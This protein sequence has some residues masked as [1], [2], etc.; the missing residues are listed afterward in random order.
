MGPISIVQDILFLTVF[1]S[2]RINQLYFNHNERNIVYVL[3]LL[4]KHLHWSE[5][6]CHS[7]TQHLSPSHNTINCRKCGGVFCGACSAVYKRFTLLGKGYSDP[8]RL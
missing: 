5:L 7:L 1:T 6:Q 2:Y 8:V 4:N 3:Y